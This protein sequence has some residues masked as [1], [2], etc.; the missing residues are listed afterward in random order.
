MLLSIIPLCV[1]AR[2]DCRSLGKFDGNALVLCV[3]DGVNVG[4]TVYNS[5]GSRVGRSVVNA[6][7]VVITLST[8]TFCAFNSSDNKYYPLSRF[9]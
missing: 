3:S 4:V 2:E 9:M 6:N 5:L 7:D 1:G 8:T